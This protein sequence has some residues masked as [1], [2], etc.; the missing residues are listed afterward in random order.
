MTIISKLW[1][2]WHNS[3]N[4]SNGNRDTDRL[5]RGGNDRKTRS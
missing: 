2:I 4:E 5:E 1:S 3:P